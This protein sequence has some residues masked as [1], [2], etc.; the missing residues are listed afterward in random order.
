MKNNEEDFRSLSIRN[1]EE[2][3]AFGHQL[4]NQLEPGSV[5]ALIGD[6][7]TGK[8]TLSKYI[9]E[10][11]GITEVVTSP[12]FTIVQEYHT[13][14]LPLYHFD[15]YRIG[16]ISEMEE[17]GYEEYFFGDG[18]SLVEWA[19]IIQELLP[20]EARIIRIEYGREPEER[21]YH[22]NF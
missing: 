9:A 10:G 22:C 11:L 20:E 15:V 4:A 21:I 17:L 19:D 3:R 7:G 16:E 6:L 5:V 18:V 13:G 12:T 8:T 14:R 1:E 2:T